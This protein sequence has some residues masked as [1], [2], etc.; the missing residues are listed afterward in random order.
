MIVEIQ[1]LGGFSVVVDGVPVA[2]ALWRRDRA[3]ALI[4]LL[5]VC[6][7]H[8]MHREQVM[9]LF[10]PDADSELAGAALRK[11]VYYARKALGQTDLVSTNGDVVALA[12]GADLV[13]D[14]E[15]FEAAAIAAMR[16]PTAETCSAAAELWHGHLLPEDPYLDWLD[17]PRARL[18]Q[19][20]TDLLRAGRLWHQLIAVE[21]SD[22]PAQ[23]AL[24]QAALD[25]GNRGE[26]IRLFNQ[27]R[28]SLNLE[29]GLGPSA[30][31]VALYEKALAIPAVD[32]VS[33]TDRI[34]ASLAWGLLHLHSGEFDKAR[35]VAEET[36]ELAMAAGLVREIGEAS[37]LMGLCA[38]MQGRWKEVFQ[39]E[40]IAWV[41]KTPDK[42]DMVFDGHLCLAEF[43]LCN[44]KGHHEVGAGA[45]AL[46]SASEG[47]GST[48]GRGLA[49]LIL[50]EVALFSGDR[51]EAERLLAQA[52]RLLAKSNAHSGRALALERL[53]ELALAQGKKW[54]AR[55][56]ITRAEGIAAHSWLAPHLLI[57]LK[58]LAVQAAA[59]KDKALDVIHQGDRLLGLQSHGC[60]P[61]SMGFRI[62]A[63]TA[64]ADLGEVEQVSRRLDEAERIAGMWHG[65]PWAAAVW[66]ARGAQRLAEKQANRAISAFEEAA[67]R[68]AAL[69]RPTDE[70]RCLARIAEAL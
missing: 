64:L 69:G 16:A 52:D 25:A 40:F 8:R 39:T 12:P 24:M 41:R 54:Q 34:R 48:P 55:R 60:Q 27:L 63:A 47:A 29:L 59:T 57:R 37:A 1:I 17:A 15:T 5:A 56:L 62:A 21:P 18:L 6:P 42:V 30:Q 68:Y 10:W 13:I 20:Y 33:Q 11:A 53:A 61:C 22:E 44:A 4:K 19:R 28:E 58:G 31:A 23:C 14:A 67:N 38:Q 46:L 9:D 65:G 43:C 32:P 50:G 51:G 3:A 70:A 7:N 36:R 45:Q 66:E 26:A 49:S 35:A 2:P